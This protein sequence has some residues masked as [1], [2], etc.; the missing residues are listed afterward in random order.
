MNGQDGRPFSE[1]DFDKLE[2]IHGGTT[3]NELIDRFRDEFGLDKFNAYVQRG[4]AE[5]LRWLGAIGMP[6]GTIEDPA[7]ARLTRSTLIAP[8]GVRIA[9]ALLLRDIVIAAMQPSAEP[10]DKPARREKA[11]S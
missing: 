11:R 5:S 6:T 2:P 7:N 3:V 4:T 1:E 10:S 9:M 8:A